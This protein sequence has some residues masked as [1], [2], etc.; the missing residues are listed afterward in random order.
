M[1]YK[2]TQN[3]KYLAE[4]GKTSEDALRRL[5]EIT[6]ILRR[7]C[8]W[9]R[10][11]THETLRVCMIEEAYEVAEAIDNRDRVNL[12]E[13]LGDVL[14]QVLFHSSLESEE[15]NFDLRDVINDECEKMIRRHPHVFND[16]GVKN[17]DKA[18]EKWENVKVKEHQQSSTSERLKS[19][20]KALPALV[21]SYKV[22]KKAADVGFDWDDKKE[23]FA[24]ISEELGELTEALHRNDSEAIGEELGDVLFSVVNLSRFIEVD[25]EA[26]LEASVEKFIDR[27]EKME[28]LA[29]KEGRNFGELTLEEMDKLWDKVK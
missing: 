24:K 17:L 13:E 8:P 29:G 16:E 2:I 18:L 22:Q 25:P 10:E 12:K 19:V 3:Y 11:Q 27:F 15:G 20:P 21:R 1:E 5:T 14:L 23:A 7:E 28:D 26:A 6:E 9:D 4:S